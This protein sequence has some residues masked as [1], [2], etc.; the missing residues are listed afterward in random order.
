MLAKIIKI[1][2]AIVAELTAA[3]FSESFTPV[4]SYQPTYDLEDMKDLVVT[5]VPRGQTSSLASRA[6]DL[7]EYSVDVAI[8]KKIAT[9]GDIEPLMEL[10]REIA[11]FLNRRRLPAPSN[12]VT[13]IGTANDPVFGPGHLEQ[14]RQFTSVLTVTYR[15]A[16]TARP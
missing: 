10:V 3:T 15:A 2:D 12:D 8:Q 16:E 6:S 7:V 4:S 13:W 9:H 14:L 5:V 1:A 11:D